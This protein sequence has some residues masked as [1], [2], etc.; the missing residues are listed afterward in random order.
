MSEAIEGE[1]YEVVPDS[2][3]KAQKAWDQAAFEWGAFQLMV[4]D[5]LDMGP[6]DMGL[7]GRV[8]DFPDEYNEARV[9]IER[10][11][12]AGVRAL[13]DAS[14]QLDKV[15]KEYESKD[16]EYYEKFGYLGEEL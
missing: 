15:A 1:S 5:R 16:A 9:A 3:R 10:K 14:E 8:T 4:R 12:G 2:L 13:Q 11:L 6:G 7:L